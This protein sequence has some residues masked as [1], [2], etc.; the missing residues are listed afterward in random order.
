MS[1]ADHLRS[2]AVDA[3]Y[4]TLLQTIERL[5]SS[6]E[7]AATKGLWEVE[8]GP[9]EGNWHMDEGNRILVA[10]H[11]GRQDLYVEDAWAVDKQSFY[12]VGWGDEP[13]W[14]RVKVCF[15]FKTHFI[16]DP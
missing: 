3:G 8:V 11:L 2:T 16:M 9:F 6:V 5:I 15:I 12:I 4:N 14:D 1:F 10:L 13:C 7:A